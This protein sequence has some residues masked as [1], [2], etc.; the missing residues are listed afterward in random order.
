MNHETVTT[1][2]SGFDWKGLGYLISIASV[3]LLGAIA[4][5][6]AEEP[7]WHMPVLLAGMA[8]SILGM[9]CRY[10]AHLDQQRELKRTKAEARNP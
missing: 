6:T 4:W 10:K 2:G 1:A 3:F 9:A 7:D 5:P 8:T